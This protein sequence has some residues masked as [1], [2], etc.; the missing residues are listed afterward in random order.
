MHFARDGGRMEALDK[1]TP[2]LARV[3]TPTLLKARIEYGPACPYYDR[4][5][6]QPSG[7]NTPLYCKCG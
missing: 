5:M 2:A 3:T 6:H 7:V 1:Q 4:Y